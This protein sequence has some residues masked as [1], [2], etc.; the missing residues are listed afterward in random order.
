MIVISDTTPLISFLKINRLDLLEKLFC[1]V[2]IPKGVFAELIENPKYA[3]ETEIVRKIGFIKVVDKIDEGYVSLLR[4][5]TG[6]DLG[7]AK[8]FIF[9]ITKNLI[10]Y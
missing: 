4:R 7:E 9:P 1:T 10:Y 5:S 6:L 2:Q 8:R 3:T